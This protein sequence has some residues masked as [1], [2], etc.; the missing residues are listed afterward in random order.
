MYEL[1]DLYDLYDLCDMY[2]LYDLTHVAGRE[3]DNLHDLGHIY[4]LDLYCTAPARHLVAAGWKM[5][6]L[7]D[8]SVEDLSVLPVEAMPS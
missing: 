6:G 5:D 3:P 4:G 7:D 1:Y 8:L 2:D